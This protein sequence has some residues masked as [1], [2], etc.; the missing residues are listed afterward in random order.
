MAAVLFPCHIPP[1]ATADNAP[2]CNKRAHIQHIQRRRIVFLTKQH[3][4]HE[5]VLY[6]CMNRIYLYMLAIAMLHVPPCATRVHV[7]CFCTVL[8]FFFLLFWLADRLDARWFWH[9]GFV[10]HQFRM[11]LLAERGQKNGAMVAFGYEPCV[12]AHSQFTLD[13]QTHIFFCFHSAGSGCS[14]TTTTT[15]KIDD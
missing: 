8:F 7:Q 3:I 5:C 4:H 12:R 1:I 13:T 11:Y 9:T 15:R 14:P 10:E 6:V 2:R